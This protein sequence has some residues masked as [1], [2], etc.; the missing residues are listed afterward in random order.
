MSLRFYFDEHM[1]GAIAHGLRRVGVDV[2]T[3]QQDD[4]AGTD[5]PGILDRAAELRRVVV[6]CDDDFEVEAAGRPR[7]GEPFAGV[8]LLNE[9]RM[10][11]GECIRQLEV[12]AK[13]YDPQEMIG[14]VLHLPLW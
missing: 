13:V 7:R 14:Y 3:I 4:L 2:L 6:T 8:I 10:S 11:A 12:V 5:D 9:K 1:P